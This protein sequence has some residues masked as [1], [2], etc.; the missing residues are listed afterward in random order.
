MHLQNIA[1]AGIWVV[2]LGAILAP[3]TRANAQA[4]STFQDSCRNI[5]IAGNTLSAE[6][7]R[8]DGSFART[9]IL[10][11]GVANNDGTLTLV[12]L[13]SPSSFQNS[14]SNIQITGVTLTAA[15]RRMNGSSR[16]SSI[17]LPGIGNDN[18]VL[19]Y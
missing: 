1:A 11:R 4:A 3:I 12:N 5:A 10:L 9:S 13:G 16:D 15:C 17:L 14:C 8:I 7:R 6:C 2:L 18:G 19:R